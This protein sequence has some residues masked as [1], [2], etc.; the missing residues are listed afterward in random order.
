LDQNRKTSCHIIIKIL[1][2]QNKERL[3][4]AVK[5]E[6][7]VTKKGRPTRIIP[8]FSTKTL[9][10]RSSWADVIQ[11]LKEDKCQPSILY[12]AKLSVIINGR[13]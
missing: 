2:E 6:G 9:K 12:P 4:K 1:N 10:P 11:T 7:Q 5:E 3:L 8:D 13:N